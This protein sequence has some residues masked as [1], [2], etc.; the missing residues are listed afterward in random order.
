MAKNP[1]WLRGAKGK[2]AGMVLQKAS[3]GGTM[4]RENVTPKNPRSVGQMATRLAFGQVN[5][6]AAALNSLI[7]HAFEGVPVGKMSRRK[8]VSLNVS[9]LKNYALQQY[10][11]Q[12]SVDLAGFSPKGLN[13]P[14]PNKLIVS[15][16]SLVR[17]DFCRAFV[18]A[19][20][21]IKFGTGTA[22]LAIDLAP[23]F[24]YLDMITAMGFKPGDE[25]SVVEIKAAYTDNSITSYGEATFGNGVRPAIW[26]A[27]RIVFKG[28][29]DLISETEN[30][31]SP[32][33][34][35]TQTSD[36]LDKMIF[37]DLTT[38][39]MYDFFAGFHDVTPSQGG[40]GVLNVP[41]AW[42]LPT[43]KPILAAATIVSRWDG[44]I[45][46]RSNED[47]VTTTVANATNGWF[48]LTFD[49]AYKTYAQEKASS[50]LFLNQGGDNQLGAAEVN[51]Q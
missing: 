14:I 22:G 41:N 15:R 5:T 13:I 39:D 21:E 35:F 48:G 47:M 27:A 7:N 2:L 43:D 16:G 23:G 24:T 8:F 37:R 30:W 44:G 6:A 49:N 38:D 9:R 34:A 4:V 45:E 50:D 51:P 46:K 26:R 3:D 1:I 42:T 29:D 32:V 40:G 11:G 17:S 31:N 36:I 20:G 18:N 19:N 25:Y 28:Y 10:N 33:S 12:G